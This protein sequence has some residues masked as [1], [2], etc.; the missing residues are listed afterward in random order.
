M[1]LLYMNV[2]ACV[3]LSIKGVHVYICIYI[4]ACSKSMTM[5]TPACSPEYQRT[6]S[7]FEFSKRSKVMHDDK[8]HLDGVG[9]Q[10][11]K[12]L[13]SFYKIC[14]PGV[15]H[16]AGEDYRGLNGGLGWSQRK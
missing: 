12:A 13:I 14:S 7:A 2:C 9:I 8:L 4:C 10:V 3:F 15:Q 11:T 16:D 1:K 5:T 6:L